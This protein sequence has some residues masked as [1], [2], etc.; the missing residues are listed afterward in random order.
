MRT[1]KLKLLYIPIILGGAIWLGSVITSNAD[2]GPV[3]AQPGSVD[4]PVIT[5][6]YFD[7]QINQKIAEALAKQPTT[8]VATPSPTPVQTPPPAT[9]GEASSSLE[10]VVLPAGKTIYAGAGTELIVRTGKTIAVSSDDNGIPDVTAGKD[11]PAG[12][13]IVTNHLL[14]FPTEGRGVKA[15][16]K[17]VGDIYIM[18]RGSYIIP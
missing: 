12:Q 7:Q 13:A 11:V 3:T 4:D 1:G 15:D 2:G 14:I 6:S 8:P 9:G 5:K 16:P 10:V 18:V 17:N